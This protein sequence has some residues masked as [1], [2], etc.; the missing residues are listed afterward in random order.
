MSR[1]DAA[2]ALVGVSR[3]TFLLLTPACV[4]LGFATA[5]AAPDFA[6]P[7]CRFFLV[8]NL[9]LLNQFPDLEAD[10]SAGRRHLPIVLG[11][12][13]SSQVFGYFFELASNKPLKLAG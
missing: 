12:P 13:S 5:A 11:R 4:L 9:L 7:W 1:L 10:R 8:S 2:A 6:G 3:P